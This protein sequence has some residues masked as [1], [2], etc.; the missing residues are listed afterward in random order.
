MAFPTCTSLL[1]Y[2]APMK[3]SKSAHT[4]PCFP[5]CI[6]LL[7]G[8]SVFPVV[9][10]TQ[11]SILRGAMSWRSWALLWVG[12]WTR[13]PSEVPFNLNC[14]VMCVCACV[15]VLSIKWEIK[16]YSLGKQPYTEQKWGFL[17]VEVM[18]RPPE[19]HGSSDWQ[20]FPATVPKDSSLPCCVT[21]GMSLKWQNGIKQL[22]VQACRVEM[23]GTCNLLSKD[24]I[25]ICHILTET[26]F[27][28]HGHA[29]IQH[30]RIPASGLG[31]RCLSDHLGDRDR[32]VGQPC[33]QLSARILI[34]SMVLSPASAS[35]N[36]V[37]PAWLSH[38]IKL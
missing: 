13:C 8:F 20:L 33:S 6:V 2:K 15:N 30:V 16:L 18:P 21:E 34:R 28:S 10:L 31:N 1:S 4:L 11:K 14:S 5:L 37:L 29:H 25:S 12:V 22:H 9:V 19:H 23:G 7:F 26:L 17:D 27:L 38:E 3:P 32:A 24:Q 36:P 35:L